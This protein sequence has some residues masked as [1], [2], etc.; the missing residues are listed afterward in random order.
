MLLLALW[1]C[2]YAPASDM[3][4]R[5]GIPLRELGRVVYGR[6]LCGAEYSD[7]PRY[8]SSRVMAPLLPGEA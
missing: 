3:P 7:P 2:L 8:A 6:A 1:R 4:L 5:G